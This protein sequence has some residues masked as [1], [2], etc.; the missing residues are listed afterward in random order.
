MSNF[1]E[2]EM[3]QIK[4]DAYKCYCYFYKIAAWQL[5][6]NYDGAMDYETAQAILTKNKT[7]AADEQTAA[8][9]N[10]ALVKQIW[11][12]YNEFRVAKIYDEQVAKN[13][14]RMMEAL[15]VTFVTV[16]DVK[17]AIEDKEL[18]NVYFAKRFEKIVEPPYEQKITI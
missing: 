8:A 9:Q 16:D 1:T 4:K 5:E 11:Q 2:Q 18:Y 10:A 15:N 6:K 3:E 13:L 17:S 12:L 14:L 7:A